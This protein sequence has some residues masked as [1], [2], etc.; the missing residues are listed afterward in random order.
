MNI[1]KHAGTVKTATLPDGTTVH[2]QERLFVAEWGA[3]VACAPYSDHF[4]YE[5]PDTRNGSPG[6]VCT[7]GA[8]AVVTPPSPTGLFVCMF[9]LNS[10]LLG[11][12]STSL[13]NKDDIE[14]VKGQ[15]LDM[16][17]IRRE[18]I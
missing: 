4:V 10:G 18:L 9:D 7:C 1:I 11:Y 3:F 16:N 5:N 13:Y 14:K 2:R 12:H 6:F 17:K 15:T 8:V